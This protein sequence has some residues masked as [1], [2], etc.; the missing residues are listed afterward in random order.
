[1]H[2]NNAQNS[3]LPF[4]IFNNIY[5]QVDLTPSF[6]CLNFVIICVRCSVEPIE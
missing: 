3:E 4:A 6:L 1:M 5:I 2:G